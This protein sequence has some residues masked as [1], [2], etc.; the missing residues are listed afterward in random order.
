V[1]EQHHWFDYLR[2][3][4]VSVENEYAMCHQH[5]CVHPVGPVP[6]TLEKESGDHMYFVPSNWYDY[7]FVRLRGGEWMQK[8][9]G[10]NNTWWWQ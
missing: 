8:E 9:S 2:H 10:C 3:P 5:R 7:H 4:Y 1:V 6:P